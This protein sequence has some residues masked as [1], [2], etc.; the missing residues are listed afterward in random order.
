MQPDRVC[1]TRSPPMPYWVKFYDRPVH[2]IFCPSRMMHQTPRT[3]QYATV[4]DTQT[5][6]VIRNGKVRY[7]DVQTAASDGLVSAASVER[8]LH[9]ALVD[10]GVQATDLAI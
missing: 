8:G 10:C 3:L 1:S 9:L 6:S 5:C 2:D 4:P 7:P